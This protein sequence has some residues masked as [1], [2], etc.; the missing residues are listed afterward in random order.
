MKRILSILV[1]VA[2]GLAFT[3]TLASAGPKVV[4]A[5]GMASAPVLDAKTGDWAGVA[6]TK[7]KVEPALENDGKNYTGTTEV[8][9]KAAVVGDMIYLLATWADDTHDNTHKTLIWDAA[10]DAYRTGK[11]REDRIAFSFDMGKDY[12]G[13]MLAGT[14]YKAD[15]WHWKAYRS[16]GAG[17]AQDKSHIVSYSQLPKAKEHPGRNGKTLWVARPSDSGSKLYKSQRLI[18]KKGDKEP[19]YLVSK[20]VTGSI[21]DVKSA[22][23]WAN[24]TW[25][26]EMSRKLDTGHDDDLKFEKGKSYTSGMAV[27]NHTGDDHHS[28]TRWTLEIAN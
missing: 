12:K 20:K 17:V 28:T 16:Q 1:V 25:T 24:N 6:A 2:F 19:K 7:I 3:V 15:V 26:V 14:E 27:F 8:E 13:C 11:D 5:K 10:K 18:D 22:A 4:V 21:A 9:I 23:I